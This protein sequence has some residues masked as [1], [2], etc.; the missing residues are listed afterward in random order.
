MRSR[1]KAPHSKNIKI[2]KIVN[3]I[4]SLKNKAKRNFKKGG[5]IYNMP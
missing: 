1:Y 3:V 5:I 2:P 4:K